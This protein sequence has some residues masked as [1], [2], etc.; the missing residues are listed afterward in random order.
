MKEI[1]DPVEALDEI[2]NSADTVLRYANFIQ[3][4]PGESAMLITLAGSMKRMAD[5][6]IEYL[7]DQ[8]SDHDPSVGLD[9][10]ALREALGWSER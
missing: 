4:T 2:Q 1:T 8:A 10:S 9:Q 3:F 6:M 5:E 7:E